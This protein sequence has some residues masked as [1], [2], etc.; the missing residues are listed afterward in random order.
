M[1]KF[2]VVNDKEHAKQIKNQLAKTLRKRNLLKN[3]LFI[4]SI[5]LNFILLT[6]IIYI[7]TGP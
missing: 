3:I 4:S 5:L 1:A 2:I 7:K 6:V